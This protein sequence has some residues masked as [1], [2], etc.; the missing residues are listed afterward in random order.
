VGIDRYGWPGQ[1]KS[2]ELAYI[3]LVYPMKKDS[4]YVQE[5]RNGSNGTS[6]MDTAII[7]TSLNVLDINILQPY[8]RDRFAFSCEGLVQVRGFAAWQVYL[9][10]K[11]DVH[12][13]VRSWTTNRKSYD[14][15]IKGHIWISSLDFSIVRVETDLREP[16]KDLQLTRDHLVVDYGPVDFASHSKQ[17]WF[18]WS[19]DMFTEFH[20]L[21]YHDK[22][23]LTNYLLFAIDTSQRVSNPPEETPH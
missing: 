2:R 3:V 4:M 16:V 8:Y 17:L 11:P 15:P 21:R 1:V 9:V 12:D 18:P 6:G 10:Q 13:G 20:G 22:H 7:T 19:A 14:F 5:Y 23:S